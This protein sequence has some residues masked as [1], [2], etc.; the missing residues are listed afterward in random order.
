MPR[1]SKPLECT[2]EQI[3]KLQAIVRDKTGDQ[4][5]VERAQIV[6]ACS[7]EHRVDQVANKLGCNVSTVYKWR[8][9]FRQYGMDGLCDSPRSGRPVIY[10]KETEEKILAKLRETPPNGQA[11]WDGQ[12]LG[13]ALDIPA[14]AVWRFAR[15]NNI[16]LDRQ[17]S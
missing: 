17:R 3:E 16:R 8:D 14:D 10:G 1:H 4:R 15:K 13:K 2:Q 9:R 7:G 11:R 5:L 6:L 12:S